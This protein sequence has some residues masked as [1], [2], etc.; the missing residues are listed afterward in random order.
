MI[1]D[2]LQ[3]FKLLEPNNLISELVTFILAELDSFT[4]SEEFIRILEKKK[5]ENQHSLSFCVYLTNKCKSRFYFAR[6]NA[7]KGTSV[8][9]IGVYHG[10]ALIFTLEAKLL[11]TP[12]NGEQR[13]EHEYVYGKGAG[14]QRFKEGKHGRDNQD[15]LLNENGMIGFL[16]ENDFDFWFQKVN[17]WIKEAE[18]GETELL[19]KSQFKVTAKLKSNHTRLNSQNVLLHHFWIKVTQ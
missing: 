1:N 14:I 6:E 9:D 13:D 18:W 2:G 11:P 5:N 10:A 19:E 7:Q 12:K 3:E 16:K 4:N 17:Q 15:N 8:I